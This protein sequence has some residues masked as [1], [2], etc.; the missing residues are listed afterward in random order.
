MKLITWNVQWFC[1]LDGVVDVARIVREAQAFAGESGFD[2]LCLQEVAVHY[3]QLAGGAGF[4]QVAAV[5][6]LLPGYQVFFGPGV[7]EY[8][9]VSSQDGGRQQFGNLIATRLAVH[10]VQHHLLPYPADT[11]P[12]GVWSM[13]R[14]CTCVT[15][16]APGIGVL[17]LMTTHLE[18]FSALQRSAQTQ[19]IADL[20]AQACAHVAHP[21]QGSGNGGPFQTRLHTPSA[22]VCGDWN[23]AQ[24]CA[25][26]DRLQRPFALDGVPRLRDAWGLVHG[27]DC[28][29]PPT[30]CVFDRRYADQPTTSDFA[31][32]SEDLASRVRGVQVDSRTQASDHQPI[33][34]HLG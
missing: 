27:Q 18:Y 22:I 33:L 4:D 9:A 20:H 15:V 21:P 34:L 31:F 32:V 16:T 6:A 19:A 7:D 2:A 8:S 3:P 24:G 13:P 17:R 5:Q 25:D 12:G 14:C 11:S 23:F 28:P 29:H 30:F 1:G 26:Y 10:Q